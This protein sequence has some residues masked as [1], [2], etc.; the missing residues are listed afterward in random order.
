MSAEQDNLDHQR[1]AA[2]VSF[3]LGA[4]LRRDGK[5]V[6]ARVRNL[7]AGGMMIEADIGMAR[8]DAIETELRGIGRV[9]GRVA[10]CRG[11]R[12]GITFDER[13]DP[14]QARKPVTGGA[15]TPDFVKP[16][17]TGKRSLRGG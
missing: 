6:F 1:E 7:S 15:S 16:I 8:G 12:M 9:K 17:I 14:E 3:F 2:R 4:M 13:I 10:W 5:E 11:G